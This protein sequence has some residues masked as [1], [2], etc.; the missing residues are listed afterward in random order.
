MP[1]DEVYDVT[2]T[3]Q[4]QIV[5][6]TVENKFVTGSARVTKVNAKNTD[7]KLSG[8]VFEV[9][10]DI[11]DNGGFDAGVDTLCGNMAETDNGVYELNGLRYDGVM[12]VFEFRIFSPASH[13]RLRQQEKT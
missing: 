2:V 10:R 7:E 1:S 13:D 5:S 11:N 9:Y 12:A 8:C 4:D 3:E 6:I